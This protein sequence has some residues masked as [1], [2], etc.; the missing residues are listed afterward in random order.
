MLMQPNSDLKRKRLGGIFSHGIVYRN[1]QTSES[2]ITQHKLVYNV[3]KTRKARKQCFDQSENIS[4]NPYQQR[5]IN[6]LL[7]VVD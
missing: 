1:G 2:L 7:A 6:G 4:V 5:I 3:K